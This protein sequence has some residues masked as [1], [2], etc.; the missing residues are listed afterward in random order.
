MGLLESDTTEWFHFHFSLS[1]I[2]EGNGNLLQYSCLENPRDRGA[3][4]V[5][6]HGVEQSWTPP[7]R[8]SSGSSSIP[9]VKVLDKHLEVDFALMFWDWVRETIY[10]L[11]SYKWNKVL[12]TNLWK[13]CPITLSS[14]SSWDTEIHSKHEWKIIT[15]AHSNV[16]EFHELPGLSSP[17]HCHVL[18]SRLSSVLFSSRC[19]PESCLCQVLHNVLCSL[20]VQQY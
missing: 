8:L 5:A 20:S 14:S 2:G 10:L 7:K 11:S 18:S 17:E 9:V 6:I 3:W 19:S 1:C 15:K 13:I 12:R 4:W 16:I